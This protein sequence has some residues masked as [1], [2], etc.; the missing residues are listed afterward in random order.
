M[1]E[2]RRYIRFDVEQKAILKFK[3]DASRSVEVNVLD[4]SYVGFAARSLEE[5]AVGA[6]V[7]FELKIKPFETPIIGEGK[8]VYSRETAKLE[9]KGFRLGISFTQ[10]DKRVLLNVINEIQE[11]I[12]ARTRK[13]LS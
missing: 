4:I 8:V 2:R 9:P 6:D 13:E 5:I 3:S 7:V 11:D 10:V 12:C 1:R